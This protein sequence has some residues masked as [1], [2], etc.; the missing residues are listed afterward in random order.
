MLVQEGLEQSRIRHPG[1][2]ALICGHRRLTYAEVD[3][4]ADR[5]ANALIA[6]GVRRGDR[7]GIYLQN[8]VECVIAIYAALKADATFVV[9]NPALKFDKLTYILNHCAATTLVAESRL[10]QKGELARVFD[11]CPSLRFAV[12]RG[13][14]AR[15][16]SDPRVIGFDAIQAEFPAQRPAR[17]NIDVDLACLVYTSGS[18]GEPKG[19]MCD[20]S[21]VVFVSRSVMAYLENRESDVV[22]CVLPLAFSYGLYHPLM[23]FTFGGTLVL[24]ESFAFPVAMLKRMAEERVTG[25]AGVPTIY[26][27]MLQLDL[28][29]FDLS[30]V[31]YFTNA[32]AALPEE[33]LKELHRRLPH[34]SLYSMYG[35]T[36]TKRTLYLPPEELD[37]R[38][39]SVGIAIPGTEVWIEDA[40][41]NRLG[42]DEV[43]ELVVRG[44]HVMRGY[45]NDPAGTAQRYRPG[46]VAGE[47]LC[48]TGDLFR[49]DQDGFFYFVSRSDE[50]IKCRGE[51]VAPKA[52]E[53]VLHR[54]PGVI[55][56]AVVGVP[57]ALLGQAVKAVLVADRTQVTEELVMAHCRTYLEDVMV[58]RYVEFRDELP[59]TGSGKVIRR[60]LV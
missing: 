14:A 41:G 23:T 17:K 9:V 16:G 34:M 5:M 2:T 4:M 21:N 19:V 57:D 28:S 6:N 55:L 53:N 20:H 36:E 50:I 47:R 22:M 38:P 33:H 31:R 52:V 56:A 3:A 39:G 29:Q 42:P 58:P 13:A 49:M 26:A 10:A 44:R 35:Q 11:E 40:D 45:W 18:T 60:S 15:A 24:E 7:V 59:L 30:S 37:R 12:T 32:A 54:L 51:K 27:A 48:Y 43:G 8:S 1:K 25:F 46:P